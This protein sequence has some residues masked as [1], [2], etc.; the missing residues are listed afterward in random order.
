MEQKRA[1]VMIEIETNGDDYNRCDDCG[2]KLT[3]QWWWHGPGDFALLCE[4]CWL[5]RP[6]EGRVIDE[7]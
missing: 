7:A 2:V 3:K 4:N 5:K 6:E 1:L